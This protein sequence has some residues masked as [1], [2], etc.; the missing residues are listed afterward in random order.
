MIREIPCE[1]VD[2]AV[3]IGIH[4][5]AAVL[6]DIEPSMHTTGLIY[7]AALAACLAC[8]AFIQ[9]LNGNA[10][11]PCF[12][13]EQLEDTVERPFVELPVPV[14][15]PVLARSYVLE[16]A[17]DDRG[18]AA[19]FSIA[20]KRFGE[21]VQQMRTLTGTLLVQSNRF[22]GPAFGG[23]RLLLFEILFEGGQFSFCPEGGRAV[24]TGS[25]AEVYHSEV[26]GHGFTG[27][28]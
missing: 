28:F 19:S 12:V 3:N 9:V 18:H 25:G 23:L 17:H 16:G 27:T 8:V 22:I 4:D 20:D 26:D 11:E 6:A 24:R 7:R 15:A 10:F 13:R 21:A 14:V 2:R 5:G 1:D